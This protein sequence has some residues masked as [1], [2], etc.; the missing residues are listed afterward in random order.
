[1]DLFQVVYFTALFPYVVLFILFF[2]G[3]TLPG[4]KQGIMYYITPR[5]E[6]LGNAKVLLFTFFCFMN[7]LEFPDSTPGRFNAKGCS[8]AKNNF[9]VGFCDDQRISFRDVSLGR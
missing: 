7:C 3:I 6:K 8:Y 2:R 5:F 9:L 1:M 4:A